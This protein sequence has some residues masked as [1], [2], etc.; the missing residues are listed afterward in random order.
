M[1]LPLYQKIVLKFFFNAKWIIHPLAPIHILAF[2]FE[3]QKLSGF[4]KIMGFKKHSSTHKNKNYI[5]LLPYT[6]HS[7][8]I[9][10][11][12]GMGSIS[13]N[14]AFVHPMIREALYNRK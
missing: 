8:S 3:R 6:I 1:D 7:L 10:W 14:K 5:K 12:H 11:N 4:H 13:Q 9:E 2:W